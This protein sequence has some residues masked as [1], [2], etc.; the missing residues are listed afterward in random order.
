M[1]TMD[2]YK[3][4]Y[5]DERQFFTLPQENFKPSQET[6]QEMIYRSRLMKPHDD[7]VIQGAAAGHARPAA[8]HAHP[9]SPTYQPPAGEERPVVPGAALHTVRGG[10]PLDADAA[11]WEETGN[12]YEIDE[13]PPMDELIAEMYKKNH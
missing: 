8:Q 1:M 4:E 3:S 6:T 5:I 2:Q 11:I 13:A 7:L 10:L 12:R 9:A